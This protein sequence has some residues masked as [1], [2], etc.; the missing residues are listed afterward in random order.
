MSYSGKISQVILLFI[1]IYALDYVV[2]EM[3]FWL[4]IVVA[5]LAVAT[6]DFLQSEHDI[7]LFK[8]QIQHLK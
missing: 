2:F 8:K 5:T 6:L 3:P 4:Y 1:V 7:K